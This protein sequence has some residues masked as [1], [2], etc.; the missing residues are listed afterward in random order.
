MDYAMKVAAASNC[1]TDSTTERVSCLRGVDGD[2]LIKAQV[3]LLD[4]WAF[5][6]YT[7]P[8]I[9]LEARGKDAFL[10]DDPSL[11]MDRGDF[12]PVPII[13]G[14]T[15]HEGF[16]P[17]AVLQTLVGKEMLQNQTYFNNELIPRVLRAMISDEEDEI[18]ML[19]EVIRR[20]YFHELNFSDGASVKIAIS[21][22]TNVRFKFIN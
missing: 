4:F 16:M 21:E 19:S 22:L 6:V 3:N 1:S 12:N 8:V 11:L 9:D 17:Y 15:P 13:T 10:A 18:Y 20:Q 7:A 5:P 2:S 14:V